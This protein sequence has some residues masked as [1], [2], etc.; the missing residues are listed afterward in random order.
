MQSYLEACKRLRAKK[1][2]AIE[3][4]RKPAPPVVKKAAKRSK[5]S[6]KSDDALANAPKKVKVFINH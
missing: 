4:K 5:N 3:K 6:Q 1:P 2:Q